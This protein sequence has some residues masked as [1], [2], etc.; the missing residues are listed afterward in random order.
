MISPFIF[1]NTLI[2][3]SFVKNSFMTALSTSLN[4][5]SSKRASDV[6]PDVSVVATEESDT[7]PTVYCPMYE[8][9]ST[10]ISSLGTRI[11]TPASEAGLKCPYLSVAATLTSEATYCN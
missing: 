6:M 4:V 7:V 1:E 8:G 2:I 9:P 11:L 3:P 5:Q 10:A